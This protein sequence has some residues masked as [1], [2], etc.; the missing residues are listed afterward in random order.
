MKKTTGSLLD[1]AQQM[2]DSFR[3]SMPVQQKRTRKAIYE[4]VTGKPF[5]EKRSNVPSRD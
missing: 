5:C 4:K 1:L 3:R 2:A